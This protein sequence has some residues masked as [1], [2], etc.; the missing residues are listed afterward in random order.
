MSTQKMAFLDTNVLHYVDLYLKHAEGA[1]MYPFGGDQVD[2]NAISEARIKLR[3]VRAKK[4]KEALDDG[5]NVLA[6]ISKSKE[7]VRVEYSPLTG[8]ELMAGRLKGRALLDAAK[9]GIP[10]R[11]WNRFSEDEIAARLTLRD[12]HEVKTAVDGLGTALE[13]LGIE[14][15]VGAD[16]ARDVLNLA[17]HVAGL[18][19]MDAMDCVIYSHALVTQADYLIT[20]DGYLKNTVNRIR[21]GDSHL[22]IN[23]QLRKIVS[24]VTLGGS[25]DVVFPE[26]KRPA[27]LPNP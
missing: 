27:D 16:H 11:M 6:W 3:K 25:S 18:V 17:R 7:E 21:S 4:W 20:K 5:L 12:F 23:A 13:N 24:Q 1:S 19:Y 2:D 10:D 9:E 22:E 14:V 26:A 15:A 8:L